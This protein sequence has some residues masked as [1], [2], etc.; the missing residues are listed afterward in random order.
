MLAVVGQWIIMIGIAAVV[1]GLFDILFQAVS[2]SLLGKRFGLR[3]LQT[4]SH[5]KCA[6]LGRWLRLFYIPCYLIPSLFF[7]VDTN[8][9]MYGVSFGLLLGAVSIFSGSH[10]ANP[11]N[12]VR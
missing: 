9:V 12:D 10:I 3:R 11:K 8:A 4:F 7:D 1:A 5:R 2:N 6:V